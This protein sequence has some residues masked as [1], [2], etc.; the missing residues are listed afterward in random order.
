MLHG[1]INFGELPREMF[2]YFMSLPKEEQEAWVLSG[3][4]LSS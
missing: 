2:G 3:I 1:G 4:V